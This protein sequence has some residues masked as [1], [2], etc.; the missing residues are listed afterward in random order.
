VRSQRDARSQI[1]AAPEQTE[2]SLAFELR[3]A[4]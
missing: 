4:F 2:S 1:G 3:W